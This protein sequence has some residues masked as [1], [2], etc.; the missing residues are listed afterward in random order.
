[1][2]VAFSIE[3]PSL[4]HFDFQMP[5]AAGPLT[6]SPNA[7]MVVYYIQVGSNIKAFP[8]V[9]SPVAREENRLTHYGHAGLPHD[10]R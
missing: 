5:Q 7:G 4:N 2:F 1:M 6:G 8:K 3:G 10:I 9:R